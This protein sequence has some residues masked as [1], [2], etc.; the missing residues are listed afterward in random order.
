M[1]PLPFREC[2]GS[3]SGCSSVS[4]SSSSSDPGCGSGSGSGSSSG[5]GSSSG[6]DRAL[7]WGGL[8][9]VWVLALV[10]ML[11]SVMPAGEAIHRKPGLARAG[12]ADSDLTVSSWGGG[13]PIPGPG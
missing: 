6:S 10:P 1:P 8:A 3:G 4:G 7:G 2:S 13:S 11:G 5:G 9:L 12:R